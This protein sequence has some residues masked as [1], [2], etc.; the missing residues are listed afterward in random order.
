MI[1]KAEGSIPSE[2]VYRACFYSADKYNA[3]IKEAA[4]VDY[5][6]EDFRVL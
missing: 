2:R 6:Q 5:I 3:S 4:N 1:P